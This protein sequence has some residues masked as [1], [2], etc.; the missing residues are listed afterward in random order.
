MAG[1]YIAVSVLAI[2]AVVALI[3]KV[4]GLNTTPRFNQLPLNRDTLK[5]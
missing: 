4:F 3:E 2:S 5:G 1:V